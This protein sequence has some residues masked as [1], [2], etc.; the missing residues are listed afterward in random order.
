MRRVH[1]LSMLVFVASAAAAAPPPAAR[2]GYRDLRFD[3]DWSVLA[4]SDALPSSD[5]FDPLKYVEL[6]DDVWA[7]FGGQL[8][9]RFESW[10]AYE[11]GDVSDPDEDL[12]LTR[13]LAHVDLHVAERFR[14][15]VEV[16]SAGSTDPHVFDDTR[17][18]D[19]DWLDLQNGFLELAGEALRFRLGRQ[20]LAFARQRLVSPLD[21]ANARRSFD[22]ATLE[23]MRGDWH[24]TGFATRP[25][26]VRPD[27]G[28]D[29]LPTV[30]AFYGVHATRR[31]TPEAARL[32]LY[33]YGI[34]REDGDDRFFTLGG[35]VADAI[36]DT[37]FDYDVELAGQLGSD[38]FRAAMLASQLGWW[39]AEHTLSPRFFLGFDWASGGSDGVFDQLFP[40]GHAYF[41]AIDAIGRKNLLAASAGVSFRPFAAVSAELVFHQFWLDDPGSGLFAADGRQTRSGAGADRHRVGAELDLVGKWQIDPH[42]ALFAGYGHFFP[43]P[44][45]DETGRDAATDFVYLTLQYT[46]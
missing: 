40:L 37:P 16:K 26:R 34:E 18:L 30:E 28:N 12:L 41:G 20:E 1:A 45:V 27:D 32:D 46:F 36:G 44:F 15:F 21:W 2:P 8:R 17:P 13:L 35:R 38:A 39:L 5:P 25:V 14:L 7:S 10:D 3:E 4:T 6:G 43:G 31:A 22:G 11:F 42:T 19:V 33:A 9:L 29:Y 23:W 24:A